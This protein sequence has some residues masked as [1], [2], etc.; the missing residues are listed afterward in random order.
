LKNLVKYE[1]RYL[2]HI[3]KNVVWKPQE[4]H[5]QQFWN[6]EDCSTHNMLYARTYL[7]LSD[8]RTNFI[9]ISVKQ[10]GMI[11]WTKMQD[12]RH[13]KACGHLLAMHDR[14]GCTATFP[15]PCKCGGA[16]K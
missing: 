5:T 6:I 15:K 14:E 4:I 11:G 10:Q 7:G 1:K 13:C 9:F 2:F 12:D 3:F 8:I 16:I